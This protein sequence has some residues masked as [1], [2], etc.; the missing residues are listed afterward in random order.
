M[1]DDYDNL[2]HHLRGFRKVVINTCY[3]GFCLS[4]KAVLLYLKQ[5]KTQYTTE[6]REDRHSQN[7]YG[8]YIIVNNKIWTEDDV[9]RDDPILVKVVEEL[10]DE[11][12]GPHA[13]LKIVE[14]P[15]D[16][17]WEIE[18]YDGREWVAEV[19]RVWS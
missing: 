4:I 17:K 1:N 3:G 13:K 10:G 8:S 9:P 6:P 15:T 7:A 2:L 18:D 11:S 16:V 12:W 5:S 14:I 19:H